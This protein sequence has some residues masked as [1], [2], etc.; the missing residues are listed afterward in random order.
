MSLR[1]RCEP[2]ATPHPSSTTITCATPIAPFPRPTSTFTPATT[3]PRKRCSHA[4]AKAR[5]RTDEKRSLKK[6]P[7]PHSPPSTSRVGGDRFR[8]GL[9]DVLQMAI[10]E[11]GID[12]QPQWQQAIEQSRA[13]YRTRQISALVCEFP[14]IAYQALSQNGYLDSG[15][16]PQRPE[17]EDTKSRLTKY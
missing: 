17:R 11:F 4:A 15:T 7:S 10:Y 16:P 1:S 12:A 14:D 3:A 5:A 6:E 8:P 9:E 2:K 13:E